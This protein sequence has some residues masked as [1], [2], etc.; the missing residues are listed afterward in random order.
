M[1]LVNS[2]RISLV[3]NARFENWQRVRVL[4]TATSPNLPAKKDVSLEAKRS[5]QNSSK[6]SLDLKIQSAPKRPI[7]SSN[8]EAEDLL[9]QIIIET[10][11]SIGVGDVRSLKTLINAWVNWV[12]QMLK[13]HGI[14]DAQAAMQPIVNIGILSDLPDVRR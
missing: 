2:V 7:S 4:V 6:S 5:A 1:M 13:L 10:I 3:A 12:S 11:Q 9:R 14:D 8:N